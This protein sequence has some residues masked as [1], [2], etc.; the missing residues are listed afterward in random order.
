MSKILLRVRTQIGTWRINVHTNDTFQNL[1]NELEKEHQ[2]NLNNIL[3]TSDPNGKQSYPDHHTIRDA[4]L[5]N[6][7]MIYLLLNESN[8]NIIPVHKNSTG[9]KMITKDGT[10]VTQDVSSVFQTNGF[11]PGML[12]LRSMKMQ[13]TLNEFVSLDEQFQYKIKAPEKGLCKLVSIDKSAIQEFQ[14]YMRNFDF[15]VI[16]FLN[17]I[18]MISYIIYM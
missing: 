11:R 16:R 12:P 6:G 7:T 2:V 3:F 15:R 9:L 13:W 14:N 1:K 4:N 10:I 8:G 17:Y 18:I 5:T